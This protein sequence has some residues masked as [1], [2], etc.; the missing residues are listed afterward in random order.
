MSHHP[1]TD[2]QTALR[3]VTLAAIEQVA[4]S[5]HESLILRSSAGPR[6]WVQISRL[7]GEDAL[8]CEAVGSEYLG[9]RRELGETEQ[10]VLTRLGWAPAGDSFIQWLDVETADQ[11]AHAAST[12]AETLV[13]VFDHDPAHWPSVVAP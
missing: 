5:Q 7:R 12:L 13:K 9:W 1:A 3:R 10:N 11:R 6:L 2:D 4:G 8:L